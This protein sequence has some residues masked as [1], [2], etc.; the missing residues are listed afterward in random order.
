MLGFGLL[1]CIQILNSLSHGLVIQRHQRL[2]C[3]PCPTMI[4][5]WLIKA[6][7][8]LQLGR[9]EVGWA[10]SPEPGVSGR[11]YETARRGGGRK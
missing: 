5:D 7:D 6:A 3:K 1:P 11:D 8:T 9:R 10:K 2:L 4:S